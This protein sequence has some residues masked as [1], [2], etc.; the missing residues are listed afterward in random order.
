MSSFVPLPVSPS[1]SAGLPCSAFV[2]TI[3]LPFG[4]VPD[5]SIQISH[6]LRLDGP[7]GAAEQMLMFELLDELLRTTPLNQWEH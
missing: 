3:S 5:V 2:E 1:P 6:S 7:P 4:K